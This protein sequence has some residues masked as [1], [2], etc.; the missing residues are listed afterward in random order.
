VIAVTD[1]IAAAKPGGIVIH[2]HAGKDRMGKV[3]AL[4]LHLASVRVEVIAADYA[5]SES[6]LCAL[7]EK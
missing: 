7:Y 3:T 2:F 1:A 4:L 5:A 6:V